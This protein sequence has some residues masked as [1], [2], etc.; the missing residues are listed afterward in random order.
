MRIFRDAESKHRKLVRRYLEDLPCNKQREKYL[1]SSTFN[2]M[3]CKIT[4][5]WLVEHWKLLTV[6]QEVTPYYMEQITS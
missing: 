5:L 3:E 6:F 1:N 2:R 4:V